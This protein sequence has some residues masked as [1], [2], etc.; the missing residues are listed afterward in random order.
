L[1]LNEEVKRQRKKKK[2]ENRKMS[3]GKHFEGVI[4]A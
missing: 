2:G 4:F 3:K 1:G